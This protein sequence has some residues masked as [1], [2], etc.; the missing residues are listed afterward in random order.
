MN[1]GAVSPTKPRMGT[2]WMN[3]RLRPSTTNF[4][5]WFENTESD[6][7]RDLIRLREAVHQRSSYLPYL[8]EAKLDKTLVRH[9][10]GDLV[11]VLTEKARQA[12]LRMLDRD[13]RLIK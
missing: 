2:V 12:L 3:G 13:C 4:E 6:D 10:G 7:A 9:F 5:F 8:A 1:M 11:L